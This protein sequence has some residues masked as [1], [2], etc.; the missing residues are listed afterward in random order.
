MTTKYQVCKR[1]IMDTTD[2]EIVF[3][4]N[5]YCN[6]CNNF[7]K[8]IKNIKWIPNHQGMQELNK[9]IDRIK[10]DCKNK[11]YDGIIGLSGGVDSSYLLCKLREWGL[12]PLAVH[13]DAGWNS[14]L[15][16]KNI[17]LLCKNLGVDLD[18]IVINWD[19]MRR[20]QVAFLKSGIPNQDIPQDHAFFASLYHYAVKH[21]LLYVFSGSNYATE[22]ILPKAW[23]Y[24][25]MDSKYL[26][27]IVQRFGDGNLSGFPLISFYQLHF[28]YPYIIGMKIIRPLNYIPYKK[29]DAIAELQ[30]YGWSYYGAKHWESRFTKFFQGYY[31]PTRYG[32]D[33]RKA[34][35]SSLI[36]SGEI[37]REEAL[38][39]ISKP[40]YPVEDVERDIEY[41]T[42]KL[43]ISRAEFEEMLY[44]PKDIHPKIPSNE[45]L[46]KICLDIKK[47]IDSIAK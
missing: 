36:V 6:H 25:A 23:G 20:V 28:Y 33:K 4:D 26:K 11:Q 27:A 3:D 19:A 29:K 10:S 15:A 38:V 8:N 1:C 7:F 43:K 22:S 2:P 13:V 30:K 41:L 17:E 47:M 34:H 42:K 24:D 46:K 35:L 32:Y 5:G 18:T 44:L 12:N 16:V 14:E 45:N 39:E 31:L 37:T 9:I 21:R 40:P